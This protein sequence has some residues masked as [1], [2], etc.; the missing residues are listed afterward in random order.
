MHTLAYTCIMDIVSVYL[1]EK[2][3]MT[4]SDGVD[5][6]TVTVNI[7]SQMIDTTDTVNSSSK[8]RK[9]YTITFYSCDDSDNQ[10]C[11]QMYNHTYMLKLAEKEKL[12]KFNKITCD[13]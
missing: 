12:F 10:T 4:I 6:D 5:S 3:V 8:M 13:E 7:P 9:L 11:K 1:P 2:F